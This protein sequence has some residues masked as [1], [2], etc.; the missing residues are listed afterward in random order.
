MQQ[1]ARRDGV[2]PAGQLRPSGLWTVLPPFAVGMLKGWRD[3]VKRFPV[4]GKS[5]TFTYRGGALRDEDGRDRESLVDV[6]TPMQC[7]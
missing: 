4:R 1:K 5:W 3:G 6:Q 7:R 2:T